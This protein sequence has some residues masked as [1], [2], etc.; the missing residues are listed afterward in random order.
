M[1]RVLVTGGT[2]VLGRELVPRLAH[3]GYT[4]RVMSRRR[5]QSD[6]QS[7]L[8]WAQ[9]DLESGVG[10]AEAVSGAD[11]ILHAASSPRRHTKE[12]DVLGTQRL[13]EHAHTAG[14][15]HFIYVSIVGVDRVPFGYYRHKLAAESL[16]Q[17]AGLPWS[18]LRAAQFHPF[19]DALLRTIVRLPIFALPTDFWFQPLDPG[20]VADR[21]CGCVQT[22]P[23]GRLP[24][25]GGPEVR[26]LGELARIWLEVWGLQRRLI[27]LPLPGKVAAAFRQGLATVPEHADGKVTWW[28]WLHHKYELRRQ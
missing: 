16:V 4:V 28:D 20:E 22:G 12:V 21:L 17:Q 24:D 7:E 9:A 1:P 19:M 26:T 10:L 5:P 2:G 25:L 11:V 15:P 13:L 23:A 6:G 18:I 27:H 14:T 3:A 8:E